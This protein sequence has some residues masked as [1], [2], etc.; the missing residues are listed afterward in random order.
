MRTF[1]ASAHVAD[2]GALAVTMIAIGSA[3]SCDAPGDHVVALAVEHPRLGALDHA[4]R[5]RARPQHRRQRDRQQRGELS[6]VPVTRCWMS[7]WTG[8]AGSG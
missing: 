8:R 5:A 3:I 4:D 6:R 7:P 1:S 2:H